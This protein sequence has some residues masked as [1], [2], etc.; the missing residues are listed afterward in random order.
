MDDYNQQTISIDSSCSNIVT[1][2]VKRKEK[3]NCL[4]IFQSQSVNKGKVF[5]RLRGLGGSYKVVER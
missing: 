4:H 3:K 5:S 2:W 1:A